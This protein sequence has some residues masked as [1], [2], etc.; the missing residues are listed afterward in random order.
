MYHYLLSSGLAAGGSSD[1]TIAKCDE[2]RVVMRF[3]V[4]IVIFAAAWMS[5]CGKQQPSSSAEP[6]AT[7][8]P[9]PA[10]EDDTTKEQAAIEQIKRLKIGI[11]L[12]HLNNEKWPNSLADLGSLLKA[13][14]KELIDP[15]GKEYQFKIVTSQNQSGRA[16]DVIYVWTE[17]VVGD[18]K[19][20]LGEK[21]PEEKK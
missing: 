18:E 4:C 1:E 19:K 13:E 11:N 5:G 20:V 17:R 10:Q 12:Y 14:K 8:A 6:A 15:W 21:P 3:C 9:G 2:W 16:A 7:P